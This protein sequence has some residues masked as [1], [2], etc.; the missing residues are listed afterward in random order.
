[1]HNISLPAELTINECNAKIQ[2]VEK[3]LSIRSRKLLKRPRCVISPKTETEEQPI[4]YVSRPD[5][6]IYCPTLYAPCNNSDE[7]ESPVTSESAAPL[8]I[9]TSD[10]DSGDDLTDGILAIDAAR[11]LLSKVRQEVKAI[12]FLDLRDSLLTL[13]DSWRAFFNRRLQY[14]VNMVLLPWVD[15]GNQKV[16]LL[17]SGC[18]LEPREFTVN[19]K[20]HERR[21]AKKQSHYYLRSL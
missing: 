13:I 6:A 17:F 2:V 12:K 15:Y 3:S 10:I 16:R 8:E 11:F 4:Q 19:V 21:A 5:P 9:K 20:P 18:W 14:F 7:H 1:M